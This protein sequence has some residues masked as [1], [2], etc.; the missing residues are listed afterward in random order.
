MA[1]TATARRKQAE[2][3][4]RPKRS[5]LVVARRLPLERAEDPRR[6]ARQALLSR[7]H[8]LDLRGDRRRRTATPTGLRMPGGK[9]V[10]GLFPLTSPSSTACRRAGCPSSPSTTSTRASPRRCKAGARLVMP[11]FDVPNVGRIAML[12]RAERRR[13]RLDDTRLQ[14]GSERTSAM[15][16][17]YFETLNPRK[18]CAVAQVPGLARR[19]RARRSRQGRAQGS[20]LSGH[21]SQRQGAGADR[22]RHQALGIQRHH[23]LPRPCRRLRSVAETTIARSR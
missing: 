2:R 5:R 3:S 18:A 13:H 10:A 12:M 15:K 16:L 8:R 9:P 23:G 17:Y 20:R 19:V 14:P 21:Q 11:I 1:Q 22:R 4:R 6:G 7:H